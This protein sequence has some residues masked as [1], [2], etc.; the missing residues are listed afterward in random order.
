MWLILIFSFSSSII[1]DI[2]AIRK[3]GEASMTYF[4]FD[5]W[6]ATKQCKYDLLTSLLTQLSASSGPR[7]KIISDL[8]SDYG[9]G[10]GQ[11]RPCD[12]DLAECSKEK[13]ATPDRRPIYLIIDGLD[14]SPNASGLPSP[15]EEVLKLLKDLVDLLLQISTYASRAAQKSIFDM[16]LSLGVTSNLPS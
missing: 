3:A 9:K 8:F 2:E 11:K 4:D 6:D 1:Q 16:P 14:E 15:R 12:S 13:L 7:F 5:F 10:P